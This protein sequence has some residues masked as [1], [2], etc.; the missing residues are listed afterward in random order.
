MSQSNTLRSHLVAI[1]CL[2]IV[3]A[4]F[5]TLVIADEP[6][7]MTS[8]P[9]FR[10]ESEHA[11]AFLDALG[12]TSIAVL[13][14]IV[15]RTDRTAHSFA[16]QEQIVAYLNDSGLASAVT[17]PRR[18]DLGP[19][20]RPSQWELFQYGEE[21]ITETLGGYDTGTDYTLLMEFLVPEESAVFGIEVY[22]MDRQGRSA[23]SFLLN[24]HHEMFSRARI[25]ARNS[26]EGARGEMIENATGVGL[27]ALRLQIE[28]AKQSVAAMAFETGKRGM[29]L[30]NET[31]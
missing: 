19:L 12:N 29:L 7:Q 20:R 8:D 9:G 11:A 17:K 13:P 25:F 6:T 22:L 28:R 16:S 23:F 15:R 18:V 1:C 10:P 30:A 4:A 3:L 5:P 27:D 2:A 21:K 31:A 24:S 26:T 14:S